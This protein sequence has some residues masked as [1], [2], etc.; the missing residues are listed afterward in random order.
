MTQGAVRCVPCAG[1]GIYPLDMESVRVGTLRRAN[2]RRCG[3][4]A[5]YGWWYVKE[6]AS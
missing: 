6:H 2:A 4:C 5:G 3:A 1:S